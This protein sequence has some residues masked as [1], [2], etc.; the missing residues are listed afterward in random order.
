MEDKQPKQ[1]K[2]FSIERIGDYLHKVSPMFDESGKI[3]HYVTSPLMV[4][5]KNRD[6][7]QIIVGA[8]LFAIPVGFTQEVWDLGEQLSMA[9]ILILAAFSIISIAIFV[10]FNFYR[11]L[12]RRYWAEY[13]KRVVVIY[14][15]A[16]L[17]VTLMLTI[18]DK[19]PWGMDNLLAIKRILLV[20]FPASMS[21][22]L[23]DMLK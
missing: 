14:G 9:R 22:A 2:S 11:N 13:I 15:I 1:H 12:L 17:M 4:E 21:G 5:L 19:A 7:L 3:I 18:I 6:V 20:T 10:Y 23:S 16:F 8:T